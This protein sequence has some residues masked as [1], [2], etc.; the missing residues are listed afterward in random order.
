MIVNN[1][2]NIIN[3]RN[4]ENNIINE[5]ESIVKRVISEK[6]RPET[7]TNNNLCCGN[8][9]Y[10]NLNSVLKKVG[11][12]RVVKY[13]KIPKTETVK[14]DNNIIKE[15]SSNHNDDINKDIE[16]TCLKTNI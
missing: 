3:S 14:I 7:T 1:N 6:T 15:I 5:K 13:I 2:I 12:D 8:F 11:D 4:S 9:G 10:N 16:K